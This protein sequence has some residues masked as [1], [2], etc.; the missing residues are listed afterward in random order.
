MSD[1]AGKL[2]PS[3][4][5]PHV[6]LRRVEILIN[7]RSGGV[8][9]HAARECEGLIEAYPID[10]DIIELDPAH[11]EEGL[12][13]ALAARPDALIV[14]AGDGTARSAAAMAGPDGPLIAPLPG[15]TMNLLP[16]ALYGTA[17]WRAALNLALT[18]G[19][20]RPVPGGEIEGL[21][22][23][24]AAILGSPA[25]W[26]PAREAVRAGKL[27]LAWLYARRALRRLL[28]GRI[29][30]QLEGGRRGRAHAMAVLTP[31]ISKAV[32][33]PQALE[34]AVMTFADAS[35]A[36]RLAARAVFEDWRADPAIFTME[37][38]FIR[39]A[40]RGRVPALLDGELMF[41]GR[42]AEVVFRK[43]AFRALA[44]APE[45]PSA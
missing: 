10:A 15:G 13:R 40:A 5:T 36:F 44:P 21:P 31:L 38:A 24:V 4:L 34:A 45:T 20:A 1:V 17:D 39:V 14:L 9:P 29:R 7:P 27:K 43:T 2:E 12:R 33:P 35:E 26:A 32:P 11:M 18:E 28:G 3:R 30:F 8:G 6:P 23:Y 16:K 41:L 37:T 19:T 22:F 25:L 42:E